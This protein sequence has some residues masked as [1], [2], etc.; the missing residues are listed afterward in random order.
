MKNRNDC[1]WFINALIMALLIV[2][3]VAT[4]KVIRFQEQQTYSTTVP[5]AVQDVKNQLWVTEEIDLREPRPDPGTGC[6][7][8]VERPLT[9]L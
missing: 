2:N 4:I 7:M 6:E 9:Y 1:S 5:D 8:R 3:L